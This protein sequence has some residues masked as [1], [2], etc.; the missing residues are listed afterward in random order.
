MLDNFN[1]LENMVRIGFSHF[2]A[3]LALNLVFAILTLTTNGSPAPFLIGIVVIIL[4]QGLA[5]FSEMLTVL[6]SFQLAMVWM[7]LADIALT[8]LAYGFWLAGIAQFYR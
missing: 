7:L 5:Y 3:A 1:H 6:G 8:V 2:W 4:A